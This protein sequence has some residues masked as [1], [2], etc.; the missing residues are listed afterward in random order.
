MSRE[1][2]KKETRNG[3][4][5]NIKDV[6]HIF[7]F[8][9]TIDFFLPVIFI[10][11][12]INPLKSAT[13]Q[14]YLLSYEDDIA[15]I[16]WVSQHVNQPLTLLSDAT[17]TGYRPIIN[18]LFA[19]G[20]SLWG[21]NEV[22]YY[23]LNGIIFAGSMVFLYSLIK[24]LS[25]RTSGLIAVL[26]YLFLDSTFLLV[27]KINFLTTIG[28][29]FFITSS[30]Y[31]FILFFEKNDIRN[32]FIALPLALMA[33]FSKEPS[34][35][36]I[37]AVNLLYLFH[38]WNS[39]QIE[40]KI[41][42][43]IVFFNV[44]PI[45]SLV[46]AFL[47][48]SVDVGQSKT[49]PL[50]ELFQSRLQFYM[51]HELRGQLKNPFIVL[52]ACIGTFYFHN[53]G[54]NTYRK[55]SIVSI[56]NIVAILFMASAFFASIYLEIYSLLGLIIISL[57]LVMAFFF[58]DIN[59]RIGIMWFGVGIFPLLITGL[60]EQ[61]TYLA[62]PNLGMCLFIGVTLS[63]Y[64]SYIKSEIVHPQDP[65][66]KKTAS[67]SRTNKLTVIFII[68]ILLNILLQISLVPAQLETTSSYQKELGNK[69]TSFKELVEYLLS[70]A[71]ENAIIYYISV[72]QREKVGVGQIDSSDF[73][74]LLCL[75]GRCD[76]SVKSLDR[77]DINNT[78]PDSHEYI[79]LLSNQDVSIFI[80]EY[81]QLDDRGL[82][83]S[84]HVFK[85][86]NRVSIILE[87]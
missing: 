62:E 40:R 23:L 49:T 39:L 19:F 30:L 47:F 74:E 60:R 73:H 13:S 12:F 58:G 87:I 44:I 36:I 6:N 52:L 5:S 76:I 48:F 43:G 24:L 37:P 59:Q 1:K 46:F 78:N 85:N 26:L 2:S 29:I 63:K 72:N 17:G 51:E 4:N 45:M 8:F 25:D 16:Y 28:E 80:N 21:A 15:W 34:I 27:W 68:I 70:F 61:A 67:Y 7:S 65:K 11:S 71:P 9:K 79:A 64:L 56:K 57:L 55:M 41:K 50:L 69:Q 31:F 35:L 86:G 84:Q 82:F 10:L 66:V 54:K 75:K 3:K 20:Y 22:Y 81:S 18:L 53:F 14:Y 33:F 77:L 42:I 32:L 38:K 83:T